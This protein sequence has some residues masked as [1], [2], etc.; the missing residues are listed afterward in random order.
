[1]KTRREFIQKASV[2]SIALSSLCGFTTLDD[3]NIPVIS[4]LN[5]GNKNIPFEE[6]DYTKWKVSFNESE[7]TLS[8]VNGNVFIHGR[9]IFT[10]GTDQW[11]VVNSHDGVKSRYAFV[12]L[13]GDVQGYF[14][15]CTNGEEL[16]ICFYH[17][18]A[19]AYKGIL[20]FTGG[21]TFFKNSFACRTRAKEGERVLSLSC[22]ITDSLQNDSLFAPENDTILQ[23]DAGN[24]SIKNTGD[25]EYSFKMSG[26]IGESSESVFS[27]NLEKNYLKSRYVPYYHTLN[28]ERCS[29]TPTGWMSW[30]T[31]FDKATA[32]DN[33]NEAKIGKKYL[34]PFGC[35]FWSIESWQGNSD[36]LPVSNFFNMNL[37]VNEKQF[38]E[39]MKQ[40]AEDIRDLGFRPGLWMAPFGTGSEKF[41]DEHKNWFLHDKEG[42]PISSWNGRYT[43]DPTVQEALD[44]LKKMF[45][46]ASREWGY[47]FF[48]IDGMSGR[49]HN[50]CAHLYERPEIREC[51]KDPSYSNPFEKCVKTFR[52][53]IGEDRVF[54]A[55]QGHS[56]GPEAYYA[57]AARL[58]ADIVHPNQ[59]VKWHN[60][61]NQGA[62]TMN[63]IFTHNI[64]MVADPDTL[65]VHDLPLEEARVSATIVALPGQLT[66][67]GDKLAGLSKSQMKILQQTLPVADV[68][69]V[70]LY[71]Y[72]SMLQIWNLQIENKL[73]G[74]YN[75]VALFNW[76]DEAK[77][78]SF[79]MDELGLPAEDEYLIYEFWEQ[80][81]YGTI[82]DGFALEV[83]AHAVRLL[84][85]HKKQDIPQWVSSDRHITQ[86]ALELNAYKWDNRNRVIEGEIALVGSFPLT[87]RLHVP[88]GFHLADA[89][90][91]GAKCTVKEE[92]DNI[93][94]VTFNPNKTGDFKFK[95][96]F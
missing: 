31:Y 84:S 95:V 80:K 42:K 2:G 41:Y 76:E 10:S 55:C 28:R 11:T 21:I 67:F 27:M 61:Y 49:S 44:H 86:N 3:R 69:P 5:K 56:S 33:L 70:S 87:M 1:M 12:D 89:Q 74:D 37:E 7:S 64:V 6:P 15:L 35:E 24:L 73:L 14:V 66:F 54:L 18:T 93:M 50:Y 20:T 58:G 71:P 52:E 22:G 13:K 59:P 72:F 45:N 46:K 43:L 60:V 81:A 39:G 4:G 68:R 40:L 78:I 51:F 47:E 19:Q 53:G 34:Q 23:L 57:D 62:C 75:V 96:R 94:A 17:R 77:T 30:N 83:P 16:K 91:D 92:N 88:K 25:G 85:I 82:T 90:C 29:K 32:E 36:Q 26:H 8:I 79:S 65:L 38:P 48:K 9:L 63:Q